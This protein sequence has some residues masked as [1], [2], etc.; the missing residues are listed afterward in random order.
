MNLEKIAIYVLPIFLLLLFLHL[1]AFDASFY[2]QEALKLYT[3]KQIQEVNISSELLINHLKGEIDLADYFTEK[4]NIH[5]D[6]VKKLLKI[7]KLIIIALGI[8]ISS[9]SLSLII[10]KR[11]I[12]LCGYITNSSLISIA[13]YLI[14]IIIIISWFEISF[15]KFHEILFTNDFWLLDQNSLLITLFPQRFFED[16]AIRIIKN[17]VITSVVIALFMI[18]LKLS[19]KNFK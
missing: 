12:S 10:K 15:V 13:F 7:N 6:D 3:Y 2:R 5:L 8:I 1:T 11:F 19:N 17:S 14:L 18:I 9:A 4:E 16:A